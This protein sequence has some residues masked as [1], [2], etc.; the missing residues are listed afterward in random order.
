MAL[1]LFALPPLTGIS[2]VRCDSELTFVDVI[3]PRLYWTDTIG[4]V[5]ERARVP[6]YWAVT[7]C[8][9]SQVAATGFFHPR[10]EKGWGDEL[11]K[12]AGLAPPLLDN[13]TYVG[14]HVTLPMPLQVNGLRGSVAVWRRVPMAVRRRL[15]LRTLTAFLDLRGRSRQRSGCD[16]FGFWRLR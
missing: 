11:G 2:S 7:S 12:T 15:Q 10:S 13:G 6:W 4:G 9:A 8:L 5:H 3:N 1:P 16:N 14:E